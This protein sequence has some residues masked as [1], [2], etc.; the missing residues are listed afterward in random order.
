M[1]PVTGL[2]P[3]PEKEETRAL[4]LYHGKTQGKAAI[5]ICK[6]EETHQAGYKVLG[7]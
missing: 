1:E 3:S 4:V 2:G 7:T 5:F 6:R